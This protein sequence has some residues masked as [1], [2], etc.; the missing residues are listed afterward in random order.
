MNIHTEHKAHMTTDPSTS[1]K[2]ILTKLEE[3]KKLTLSFLSVKERELFRVA[4]HKAKRQVDEVFL[5]TDETFEVEAL[6]FTKHDNEAGWTASVELIRKQDLPKRGYSFSII[7]ESEQDHE[8][9]NPNGAIS[10][11]S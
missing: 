11:S 10:D 5:M 3:G 6:S 2:A 7:E 8:H 1:I 9:A 4:L